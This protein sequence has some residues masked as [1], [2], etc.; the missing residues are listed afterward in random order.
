MKKDNILCNLQVT[1]FPMYKIVFDDH[2]RFVI[3]GKI[4]FVLG[5]IGKEDGAT[6]AT[7]ARVPNI[8]PMAPMFA[9]P[10]RLKD[11]VEVDF[12]IYRISW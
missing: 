3:E 6:V 8:Y 2:Q 5:V 10:S 12:M 4:D 7:T 11:V 9:Q 1:E